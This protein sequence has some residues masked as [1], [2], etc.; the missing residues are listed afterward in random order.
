[1]TLVTA[2][3]RCNVC[4]KEITYH[5]DSPTAPEG[6]TKIKR[7]FKS[8]KGPVVKNIDLCSDKCFESW[9]VV[10]LSGITYEG[11]NNNG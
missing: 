1:M 5:T 2:T 9:A 7:V 8:I 6:W 11:E 4:E 10:N 3:I